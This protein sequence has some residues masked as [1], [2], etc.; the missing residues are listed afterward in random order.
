MKYHTRTMNWLICIIASLGSIPSYAMYLEL[1]GFPQT[2]P[3][4]VRDTLCQLRKEN[5][6]NA[7]FKR[8]AIYEEYAKGLND[9]SASAPNVT[10]AYA[11]ILGTEAYPVML[12]ALLEDDDFD[13][14]AAIGKSNRTYLEVLKDSYIPRIKKYAQEGKNPEKYR[15]FLKNH[16]LTTDDKIDE[17]VAV[18]S[19]PETWQSILTAFEKR[20]SKSESS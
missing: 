16:Y 15:Q 3:D 10:P 2:I 19:N 7:Y 9:I 13:I 1:P 20:D 14:T 11:I 6:H 12:Q 4:N 17:L 5:T 8:K 18:G